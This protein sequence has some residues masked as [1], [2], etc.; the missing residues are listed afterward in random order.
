MFNFTSNCDTEILIV[1]YNVQKV[2]MMAKH[3]DAQ[4]CCEVL[5][6][7]FDCCSKKFVEHLY[8]L[9]CEGKKEE[10]TRKMYKFYT[11]RKE[12]F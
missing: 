10:V 4:S 7:P 6:Y 11:S 9:A 5:E 12:T 2:F 3:A 1:K 8:N